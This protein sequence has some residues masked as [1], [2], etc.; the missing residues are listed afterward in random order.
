MASRIK[1]CRNAKRRRS[2]AQISSAAAEIIGNNH[3]PVME[4][5]LL[6]P[7]K[8]L[9]RFKSVSKTWSSL[10]SDRTFCILWQQ[11]RQSH[12]LP[13][14]SGLFFTCKSRT[15][16]KYIPLKDTDDG[17]KS[18][19]LARFPNMYH[20]NT[21]IIHSCNGLLLCCLKKPGYS[22]RSYQV[23]NPTTKQFRSLP[24]PFSRTSYPAD[25]LYLAFDPS[26]S[27]HY[28]VVLLQRIP[29]KYKKNNYLYQIH[30]YSSETNAW[31]PF[32][33][34]TIPARS[35][36]SSDLDYGV[37]SNGS[38]HWISFHREQASIY[39][40]VDQ[41]RLCPM[42]SL[43]ILH[44][45]GFVFRH[46]GVSGGHL[47]F[48]Q[49]S[50][51]DTRYSIDISEM[52][53]DYSKWSFKYRVDL[54]MMLDF[55]SQD[56]IMSHAVTVLG[57]VD[58][59]DEDDV[60]LMLFVGTNMIFSYNLKDNT[61]KKLHDVAHHPGS[62]SSELVLYKHCSLYPFIETLLPLFD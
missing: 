17:G 36:S 58:G 29:H 34:D 25:P 62:S 9:I 8:S 55:V 45:F 15:Q 18:R 7:P 28:K 32:G 33:G 52:E 54:N 31:R 35:A 13:K 4:I 53:S 39:F 30:I 14:T 37:Y 16:I 38:I 59:E 60:Y 44:N 43:P 10:I 19:S 50:S 56:M 12:D 11:R 46:F 6:L 42:P 22:P 26:K 21:T 5:L 2:S 57:L 20:I 41:E 48:I 51:C 40:D 49:E 24:W 23:Y 61:F 1:R 47:H 3:D 27:L